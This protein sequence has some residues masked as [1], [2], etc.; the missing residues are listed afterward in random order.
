MALIG[1]RVFRNGMAN[2]LQKL[3]SVE[4]ATL[5]FSEMSGDSTGNTYL[6]ISAW[7]IDEAT[8]SDGLPIIRMY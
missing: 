2:R 1:G 8:D 4:S 3:L 5:H 7:F 6:S